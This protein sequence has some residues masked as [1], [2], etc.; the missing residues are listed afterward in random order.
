MFQA[1]TRT[2]LV[3]WV[4]NSVPISASSLLICDNSL[5][6]TMEQD[7]LSLLS[8][9]NVLQRGD[10][11]H[12]SSPLI[13]YEFIP[14]VNIDSIFYVSALLEVATGELNAVLEIFIL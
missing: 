6:L 10:S 13:V 11:E 2:S 4:S 8:L 1:D 3:S 9:R 12:K 14:Y 7:V 5:L